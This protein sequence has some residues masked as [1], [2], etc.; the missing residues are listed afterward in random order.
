MDI[1]IKTSQRWLMMGPTRCGKTEF[2]KFMLRNIAKRMPVFIVDPKHLWLGDNPVWEIDKRKP[3]TVDK[4]HLVTRYNKKLWVQVIQPVIYDDNLDKSF[5]DII[6]QK[7]VYVHTDDNLGLCDANTVPMGFR[8][9]C[10][11]GAALHIGFNDCAQTVERIPGIFKSQAENFVIFNMGQVPIEKLKE[12]AN[13]A[14]VTVDELQDLEEYE[15]I[16]FQ[17]GKMKN[18]LWMPPLELSEIKKGQ[19][20]A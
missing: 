10:Q 11:M 17:R 8:K 6:E 15:Y 9:I 16:L 19:N 4:P 20:A 2:S 13:L 18:G 14:N 7:Y 3:G 12:A 5:N 1:E